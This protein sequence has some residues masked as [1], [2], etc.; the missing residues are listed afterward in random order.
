MFPPQLTHDT[1]SRFSS[2]A[3]STKATRDHATPWLNRETAVSHGVCF[4]ELLVTYFTHS[5]GGRDS[6]KERKVRG[7]RNS[8]GKAE[9]RRTK[10][11]MLPRVGT[12][13]CH[14]RPATR[15]LSVPACQPRGG[16][17]PALLQNL[18]ASV[19][20]GS[21]VPGPSHLREGAGSTHR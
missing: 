8:K 7:Q 14:K 9:T 15:A 18:L 20:V 13:H 4:S 6:L 3:S 17:F 2:S 19:V 12:D 16:P 11:L 21:L 1:V 10:T 5:K